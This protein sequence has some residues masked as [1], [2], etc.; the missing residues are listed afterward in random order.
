VKHVILAL[1][2]LTV[3]FIGLQTV[4]ASTTC[5]QYSWTEVVNEDPT[6]DIPR[7]ATV[8]MVSWRGLALVTYSHSLIPD[9]PVEISIPDCMHC[10]DCEEFFPTVTMGSQATSAMGNIPGVSYDFGWIKVDFVFS[11]M[12][13]QLSGKGGVQFMM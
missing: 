7:T 8:G 2:S 1:L 9:L 13:Y 12:G 6:P 3:L 11:V 4:Q 5:I 10:E